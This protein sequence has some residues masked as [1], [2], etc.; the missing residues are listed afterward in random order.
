MCMHTEQSSCLIGLRHEYMRMTD[1]VVKPNMIST[2]NLCVFMCVYGDESAPGG[3]VTHEG[4]PRRRCSEDGG[5]GGG[6][7]EE[8]AIP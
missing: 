3:L 6:R 1:E 7:E 2:D 5:G 4:P 8:E